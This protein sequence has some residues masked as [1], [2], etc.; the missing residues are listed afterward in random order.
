[1]KDKRLTE[2]RVVCA[3]SKIGGRVKGAESPATWSHPSLL[4]SDIKG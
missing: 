2:L 4:E 1:M 3:N